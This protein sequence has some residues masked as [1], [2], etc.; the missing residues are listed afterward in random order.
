MTLLNCVAS[1]KLSND[2]SNV[3][4]QNINGLSTNA[5]TKSSGTLETSPNNTT[6]IPTNITQPI[7]N[8][9]P[10]ILKSFNF[11]DSSR[12][13]MDR[14]K[15][16]IATGKYAD[17]FGRSFA[18]VHSNLVVEDVVSQGGS[19]S[20]QSGSYT[21]RNQK[22]GT[23]KDTFFYVSSPEYH[24]SENCYIV[25]VKSSVE[26]KLFEKLLDVFGMIEAKVVKKY[27]HGFLG[28]SICFPEN[29]LPLALMKEI[30]SIDF[31]ER[32]N[33]VKASQV[34]EN[35]PWGLARLSSPHQGSTHY[36]F[37]GTGEGVNVYVLDSG[38]Y[39]T[40]GRFFTI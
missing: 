14:L 11:I 18:E 28:Y 13:A 34:Q 15:E 5:T 6:E 36:N 1:N 12:T 37:D 25:K 39:Q 16:M 22:K 26:K 4:S 10:G 30:P 9:G 17:V 32:D 21:F 2:A 19:V 35:A 7:N 3:P 8:E 29:T 31:I 38:L 27:Q 40:T 20:Q 24:T 23:S 33:I